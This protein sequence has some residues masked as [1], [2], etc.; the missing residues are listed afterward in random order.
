MNNQQ[1]VNNLKSFLTVMVEVEDSHEVLQY[2]F[3]YYISRD[4]KSFQEMIEHLS[5]VFKINPHTLIDYLFADEDVTFESLSLNV[6]KY[7]NAF[8]LVSK[9]KLKYGRIL[10]NS[11]QKDQDP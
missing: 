7:R 6:P 3:E 1:I 5:K 9:I 8:K 2:I 11:F 10:Y 4:D